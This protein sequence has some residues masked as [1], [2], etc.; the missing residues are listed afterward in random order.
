M[1]AACEPARR[2]AVDGAVGLP[3]VVDGR[4][5]EREADRGGVDTG[6]GIR[7]THLDGEYVADGEHRAIRRLRRTEDGRR[8][9]RHR[10][11]RGRARAV[12]GAVDDR[13][14]QRVRAVGERRERLAAGGAAD[15]VE[16]HRRAVDL[17]QHG[18]HAAHVVGHVQRDHRLGVRC[19][20]GRRDERRSRRRRVDRDREGER[21]GL[22]GAD[23]G[24]ARGARV[25]AI[26]E[27][28]C[29]E[30]ERRLRRRDPGL[31]LR[32]RARRDPRRRDAGAL[33]PGGA[34]AGLRVREGQRRADIAVVPAAVQQASAVD[35][36]ERR[37][38]RVVDGDIEAHEGEVV[39]PLLADHAG[40]RGVG[41]ERDAD[42][43]EARCQRQHVIGQRDSL[44]LV[45]ERRR[46]IPGCAVGARLDA[47]VELGVPHARAIRESPAC[48]RRAGRGRP[49]PAPLRPERLSRPTAGHDAA[50]RGVRAARRG[51]GAAEHVAG[52]HVAAPAREIGAE[53]VGER[54][55]ARVRAGGA[56]EQEQGDCQGRQEA[57]AWHSA[58]VAPTAVTCLCRSVPEVERSARGSRGPC[59]RTSRARSA[60]RTWGRPCRA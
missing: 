5:V 16:R 23:V 55:L 13:P 20:G 6:I 33:E 51:A 52:L 46:E 28:R 54:V 42:P 31:I 25:Q 8:E 14:G 57:V 37:R 48:D 32:T 47:G 35:P 30:A 41:V 59:R 53:V 43:P 60:C 38:R 56:G 17:R 9:I 18:R 45:H 1:R 29:R 34:E 3:D 2:D 36:A 27:C 22:S 21:R 39:V 49:F 4:P 26:A 58:I 7:D 11:G 15:E 24:G 44:L 19:H 50:R 10:E 12:A 40:R